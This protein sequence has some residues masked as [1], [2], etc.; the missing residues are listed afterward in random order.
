L[1][2][3]AFPTD[4]KVWSVKMMEHLKSGY[5]DSAVAE[6]SHKDKDSRSK[7]STSLWLAAMNIWENAIS[8][9]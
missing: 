8:I 1:V 5:F 6:L 9:P 2:L 3:H 7:H 4:I